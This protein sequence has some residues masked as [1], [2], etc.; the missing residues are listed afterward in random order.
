MRSSDLGARSIL[1][2]LCLWPL[3]GTAGADSKADPLAAGDAT[4]SVRS[5]GADAQQGN[6]RMSIDALDDDLLRVRI[7]PAG[8]YPEDA[9]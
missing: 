9:S 4:I 7:A 6:L 8:V 3:G 5:D 1:L 2:L